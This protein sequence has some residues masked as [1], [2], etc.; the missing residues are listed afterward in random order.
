MD[1]NVKLLGLKYNFK[2][3]Q[4]CFRKIPCASYFPDLLN[5]FST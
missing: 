2:K 4:G 1:L 3:F 5:R